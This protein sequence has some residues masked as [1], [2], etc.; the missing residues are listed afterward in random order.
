MAK[1]KRPGPEPKPDFH[2]SNLM[3]R[4]PEWCRPALDE[5]K[6]KNRRPFTIEI[7]IALERHCQAEGVAVPKDPGGAA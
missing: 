1:Q 7:L 4:L 3:V 2:L 6:A 5:L